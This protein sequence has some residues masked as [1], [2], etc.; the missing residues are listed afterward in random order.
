MLASL[1]SIRNQSCIS[2]TILQVA[3]TL[4]KDFL[5]Q[6]LGLGHLSRATALRDHSRD[7]YYKLFEEHDKTSLFLI[8]D[9]TYVYVD[10]PSDF[11]IQKL[12]WSGQKKRNLIKPFMIVLPSGY[13]LE[14]SPWFANGNDNILLVVAAYE[15]SLF[16]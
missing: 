13:I 2:D 3:R 11:E 9:G 14:A 10:K 6:N 16:S 7:M 15:F 12:T 1:F 8:M 4:G 5:K